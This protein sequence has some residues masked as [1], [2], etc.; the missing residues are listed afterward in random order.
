VRP[1][2]V[3]VSIDRPA[4]ELVTISSREGSSFPLP[5]TRRVEPLGPTRSQVTEIVE[6]DPRGFYRT[7]G[8]LLPLDGAPQHPA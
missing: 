4:G 5:V 7:A 6:S 2:T 3:R 1:V 8:P